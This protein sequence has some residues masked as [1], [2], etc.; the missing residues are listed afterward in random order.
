MRKSVKW[1]LVAHTVALFLFVTTRVA[2][3]QYAVSADYIDNRG[4]S[5]SGRS[6]PGPL[7]YDSVHFTIG[8]FIYVYFGTFPLNQWLADGLMVSSILKPTA[9][10]SYT[11]H[12][13]SYI[14]AM[15]FFL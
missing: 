1:G 12:S 5:G 10:M 3:D 13:T 6:F 14:V 2:M 15:S 9:W 4:F 8:P 11:V 7:G